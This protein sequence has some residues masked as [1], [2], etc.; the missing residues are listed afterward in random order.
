M[1]RYPIPAVPGRPGV[2]AARSAIRHSAANGGPPGRG[3]V[4]SAGEIFGS[5]VGRHGIPHAGLIAPVAGIARVQ[6]PV[7]SGVQNSSTVKVD[8]RSHRGPPSPPNDGVWHQIPSP[9]RRDDDPTRTTRRLR[10]Y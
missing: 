8:Q 10:L 2:L 6:P 7:R 5:G 1:Y 9:R 3:H 4:D